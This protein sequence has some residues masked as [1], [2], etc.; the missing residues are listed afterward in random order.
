ME[1]LSSQRRTMLPQ[2]R[3]TLPERRNMPVGGETP[4]IR[5]LT[6]G[7][8]EEIDVTRREADFTN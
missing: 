7:R 5:L 1:K 3:K 2:R 8:G 4:P 6:T